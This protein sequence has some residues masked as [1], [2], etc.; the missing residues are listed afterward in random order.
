RPATSAIVRANRL[1]GPEAV[2]DLV[3]ARAPDGFADIETVA[4]YEERK[5]VVRGYA[6]LAGFARPGT[7]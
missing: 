7:S 6:S 1:G 3:E 2:I 5:E 4:S